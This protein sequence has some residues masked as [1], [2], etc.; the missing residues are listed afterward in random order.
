[1]VAI[2]MKFVSSKCQ[3]FSSYSLICRENCVL[4]RLSATVCLLS[5]MIVL[6]MGNSLNFSTV[7]SFNFF[8]FLFLIEKNLY[9]FIKIFP[10]VDTTTGGLLFSL[11]FPN[12]MLD[13][14]L[15]TVIYFFWLA[16]ANL[17]LKNGLI[18]ALKNILEVL[19]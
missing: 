3:A 17:F 4:C 9:V 11:N 6:F 8:L 5:G 16:S 10:P 14:P 7:L 15:H 2:K 1:M 12:V 18:P 13:E 19:L